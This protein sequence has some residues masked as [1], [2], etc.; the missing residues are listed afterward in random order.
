MVSVYR[1]AYIT[2][3]ATA[4]RNSEEGCFRRA[5]VDLVSRPLRHSPGLMVQGQI[6]YGNPPGAHSKSSDH[7][8]LTRT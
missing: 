7:P 6:S 5:E 1:H 8:L 4:S 3:A 2:I